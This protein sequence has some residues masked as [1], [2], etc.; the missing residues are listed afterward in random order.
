MVNLGVLYAIT[1]GVGGIT[2]YVI[3]N[4]ILSTEH[5]ELI[6]R[7]LVNLLIF[8]CAFC[9]VDMIWGLLSSNLLIKSQL[10][11][12]IFTYGFHLGAA[13]SAFLWAGYV[14]HF[15]RVNRKYQ[16]ILNVCRN[17]VLIIQ[18]T[19]LIANIWTN[20]FFYVDANADYHSLKLRNFMFFMQFLYY[21][22]LIIFSHIMVIVRKKD[23]N[24]LDYETIRRYRSALSFSFVPLA[25]GFGQM[26]WPDA[27]MYS[28]GFMLTAVLIYSINISAEREGYLRTI[29][30][31][32]NSKLQEVVLGLSNDYQVIYLL[33]LD[34]DEYEVFGESGEYKGVSDKFERSKDFFKDF[35]AN[36]GKVVVPEDCEEVVHMLSKEHITSEL[37]KQQSYSFNYR[38]LINGKERYFLC[39]V[40]GVAQ[41]N[42]KNNKVI[43]GIFDDDGRIRKEMEQRTV[44]EDALNIAENSSKAKTSF[45]FN[46]SHD[47]RTPMNSI[48]GFTNI[49]KK[50]IDDK[51]YVSECLNKVSLSSNHLL[52]LIN[53][54]LDMSRI[55]SGKM[56]L[57][58]TSESIMSR[59]V[60]MVSLVRELALKKSIKFTSKMINIQK[61]WILCDALHLNQIVLNILSNAINYTNDGGKVDYSIEEKDLGNNRVSLTFIVK[62]TG[63]GM[64]E[65]FLEKIFDEFERENSATDSGVQGTGL[66]MSIVKRLVDMMGGTINI[67]STK[68][69]GTT[70]T[71]TLDFEVTEPAKLKT[72]SSKV[73]ELPKGCRVLLVDDNLLNRE[74]AV[75]ILEELGISCEEASDGKEAVDMI[76]N[77]DPGYY[78]LV[79]MDV[80]MPGMNGYEATQ[81]IRGLDN[82]EI[83]NIPIIA[84]T[85]NAFEEDKVDA[86]NAGMNAHLSKPIDIAVLAKTLKEFL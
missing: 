38:V 31:N 83:A 26:L 68:G 47:I 46:M 69:V 20:V 62:D 37:S 61:E 50:H 8:F 40:I 63:I 72:N 64:S 19:V 27:S 84:M 9:T 53:D 81:K 18:L 24:G 13:L 28:L 14:M 23:K 73:C 86:Y 74:I 35:A 17:I 78:A 43:L 21:I 54:V 82:P 75:D 51:E 36:L 45:L 1:A 10:I 52:S 48:I 34:T 33:N 15:I 76:Q 66:G 11:Y 58:M 55:E 12:T 67:E 22:A 32:E 85:A 79:L 70:V 2:I 3:L 41:Q 49:A 25:F 56:Q 16:R 5:K 39:K 80:Q 7:K 71:L 59:N 30:Q 57:S 42:G 4:R 60:Q 29:Y 6:D 65:E 44:L 77:H